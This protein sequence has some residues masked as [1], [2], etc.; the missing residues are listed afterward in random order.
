[1]PIRSRC[2]TCASAL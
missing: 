1:L 2:L